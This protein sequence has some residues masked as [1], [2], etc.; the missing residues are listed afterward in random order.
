[1]L[2]PIDQHALVAHGSNLAPT[3]LRASW[4]FGFMGP[5]RKVVRAADCRVQLREF[6]A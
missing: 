2:E 4:A 5:L 3:W 6:S 1:M